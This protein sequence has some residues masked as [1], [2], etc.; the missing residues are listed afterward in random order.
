MK[1]N[2]FSKSEPLP[3]FVY[4]HDVLEQVKPKRTSIVKQFR[5]K[6]LNAPEMQV[7]YAGLGIRVLATLID[8][9]IIAVVMLIPEFIFFS[10]NFSNAGYNT[11]RFLMA[12]TMWVFYHVAFN[13]SALQ[14][15]FGKN[16]LKLK[17]VDLFGNRISITKA[18]FRNLAVFISVATIGLGIWY[19]STD[20]KN[21]GWHDLIAGTYVVKLLSSKSFS[22]FNKSSDF[23]TNKYASA[24]TNRNLDGSFSC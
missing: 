16:M 19:I 10:F 15:T 13:S 8:L 4:G 20:S 18:L 14:A 22:H 3:D 12:I 5:L 9:I 11:F 1:T 23:K 17:V 2:N 24:K 21:R 6:P 7:T